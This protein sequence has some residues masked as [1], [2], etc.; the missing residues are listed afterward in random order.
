VFSCRLKKNLLLLRGQEFLS[1]KSLHLRSRCLSTMPSS[2]LPK[3]ERERVIGT[4]KRVIGIRKRH[5]L[6]SPSVD[7]DGQDTY[8]PGI[9]R[10]TYIHTYIRT[11]MNTYLRSLHCMGDVH[12]YDRRTA[13]EYTHTYIHTI[14]ANT[15]T[16]IRIPYFS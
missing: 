4:R 7:A 2:S 10:H 6:A 13:D 16:Y 15:R 1:L 14:R 8:G 5:T 11:C 3:S 9:N 12:T